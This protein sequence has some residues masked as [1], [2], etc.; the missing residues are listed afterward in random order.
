[1]K[2]IAYNIM[3]ESEDSYWWYRARRQILSSIIVRSVPTGS[4]I[5]DFGAGT[6]GTAGSLRD[7]GYRIMAADISPVALEACRM[8]QLETVNLKADRLPESSADCVLAGDVLEHVSDDLGLLVSLR[9]ALRPGGLLV[10][11][12]PAY[13]FLW[14]GEDYVSEHLRRYTRGGLKRLLRAA[15]FCSIRC[16]YYNAL[17]FPVILSV[18]IGKR[19]LLPRAMYRSDVVPLP[20]WQNTLL[21]KIFAFEG[22]LLRWLTFPVGASLLAVARFERSG[23][24]C[25]LVSDRGRCA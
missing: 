21:Y 23:V 18:T 8:R 15:G 25:D 20:E 6:G 22:H 10:V 19:L 12:V 1:M 3:A 9:Q 13:E 14:S 16:S 11:T 7:L 4:D 24:H 5:I 2:A 17:L